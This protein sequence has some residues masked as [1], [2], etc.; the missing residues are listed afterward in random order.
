MEKFDLKKDRWERTLNYFEKQFGTKPTEISNEILY[1]KFVNIDGVNQI[2]SFQNE[3]EF[4]QSKYDLS[5]EDLHLF[6]I[7]KSENQPTKYHIAVET[8]MPSIRNGNYFLKSLRKDFYYYYC[9]ENYLTEEFFFEDQTSFLHSLVKSRYE[10]EMR[11]KIRKKLGI[12]FETDYSDDPFSE[13]NI[14]RD[15]ER[16]EGEKHGFN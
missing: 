11:M 9:D 13:E 8:Y 15:L 6:L 14:M 3:N 2:V 12:K 7:E 4:C 16:G 10:D 1:A 5:F